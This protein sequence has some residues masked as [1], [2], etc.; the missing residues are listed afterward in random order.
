MIVVFV[1]GFDD[2]TFIESI[3]K[4]VNIKTVPYANSKITKVDGILKTYK[5]TQTKYIFLADLDN[6]T[7]QKRKKE[8]LSKYKN[9][10]ESNIFFSI[11]E[12][13]S[14]YLAGIS[15][16]YIKRYSV[17]DKFL[18][19]TSDITKEKFNSI[20]KP[21]KDEDNQ[22]VKARICD[23]YDLEK[24]LLRNVSLKIFYEK[25]YELDKCG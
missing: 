25:I 18:N 23:G 20:I 8:L 17:K 21:K 7:P 11:Q 5:E 6:K 12:I 1:E 2:K 3:F 24:G 14:W 4:E 15:D 13:E 10:I 16:I 22:I 9:L 19:D